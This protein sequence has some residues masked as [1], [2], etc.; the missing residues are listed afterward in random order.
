MNNHARTYEPRVHRRTS[1]LPARI[2]TGH[3]R[4]LQDCTVLNISEDGACLKV[5][6][7]G[8]VPDNF[9]LLFTPS[10]TVRR[11]CMKRWRNGDI[12]GVEFLA[13]LSPLVDEPDHSEPAPN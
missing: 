13:T 11:I 10:G 8:I 4:Q 3:I 5:K 12:V 2:F 7:A 6:L 9:L 1:N